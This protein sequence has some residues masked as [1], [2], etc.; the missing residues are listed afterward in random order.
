[1]NTKW[2]NKAAVILSLATLA[3]PAYA[4]GDEAALD[5][6]TTEI[7]KRGHPSAK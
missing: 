4:G 6:K 7:I 5:A 3:V 2:M 1:M